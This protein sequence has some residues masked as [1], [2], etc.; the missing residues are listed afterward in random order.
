MKRTLE[1]LQLDYVDLYL[2]HWPVFFYYDN[3][4]KIMSK[5]MHVMWAEF[6]K[7]VEKGY[8]KCIGVSNYNV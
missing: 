1:K 3:G 2:D 7:L 8:T 4:K 6:E 5:P